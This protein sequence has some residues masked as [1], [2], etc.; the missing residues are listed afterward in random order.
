MSLEQDGVWKGGIWAPSVWQDGVW[1]EG[2]EPSVDTPTVLAKA[3]EFPH[4]LFDPRRKRLKSWHVH[5]DLELDAGLASWSIFSPKPTIAFSP[6]GSLRLTAELTAKAEFYQTPT[7]HWE[8]NG[9]L[10]APNLSLESPH[11]LQAAWEDDL[12]LSFGIGKLA[13]AEQLIERLKHG[14]D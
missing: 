11:Y 5:G 13:L 12:I 9:Q 7:E 2:E 3:D 6:V 14:S 8:H 1:L 10:Q 4:P